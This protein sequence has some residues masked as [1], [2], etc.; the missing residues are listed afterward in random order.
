MQPTA[1]PPAASVGRDSYLTLHYSLAD[2]DGNEYVSTFGLSPATLQMGSG[3]LAETL[4]DCL[5]GLGSGERHVFELPASEAFGEHNPRLLE[6]IARRALPP[7]IEL[8]PNSLIEFSAVDGGSS[9]AGFLRE[10]DDS[11]ALFDFNH[12]LAGKP[13]RFEVEIIAIL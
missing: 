10:F 12:P 4:E 11:S 13:I 3:E 8:R 1:T 2:L 5:L 9:F 6:R 7:E